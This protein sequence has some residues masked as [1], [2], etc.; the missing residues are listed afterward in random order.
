MLKTHKFARKPFYVDA[1]RVSE[2]NMEE[3]A[4]WCGGTVVTEHKDGKHI[5]VEVYRPFDDRQTRAFVGDW[6][7]FASS[8]YKVYT[9]KAFDKSFEKVK[10]LTKAQ[11]DEAGIKVPHEKSQQPKRQHPKRKPVPTPP[12]NPVLSKEAAAKLQAASEPASTINT[13]VEQ[14]IDPFTE[15]GEL[16]D[17]E[18]EAVVTSTGKAIVD[19]E[20]IASAEETPKTAADV[21]A[22]K[23]ISEVL[24]KS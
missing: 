17:P 21:E 23:L 1:V 7:L 8:G 4:E 14:G 24:R 16:K 9:P 10:T 15:T 13:L 12:A 5:S 22:E 20:V 11:A 2:N 6:V 18:N 19:G 3:V